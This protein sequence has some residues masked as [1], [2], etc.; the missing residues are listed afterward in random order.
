MTVMDQESAANQPLHSARF[1]QRAGSGFSNTLRMP[2]ISRPG[3]TSE[4]RSERSILRA[5][6]ETNESKRTNQ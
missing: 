3:Q 5:D 2:L 1:H 4:T 6:D